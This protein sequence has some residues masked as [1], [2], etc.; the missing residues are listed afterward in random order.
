[1]TKQGFLAILRLDLNQSLRTKGFWIYSLLFGGFV[2]YMFISGI[3]ES[4]IIGFVGLGRLLVTFMQV[5]MVIIPIYVLITVVRSI[6]GDKENN[7]MEYMLSLPVSFSSF[8]WGKF[9]AKFIVI[10]IPLLVAFFG[11]VIWGMIISLDVPWN[12]FWLYS[13]LLAAMVFCFLG[14]GMFISVYTRSQEF[15]VSSAFVIWLILVAFLDLLL[16]GMMLKLRINPDAVIGVGM[17]NPLQ[18]FRVGVL[19]L[20]DPKLTTMGPAAYYILDTVSRGVFI[21]FAII[22]PTLLGYLFAWLGNKRFKNRDVI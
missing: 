9:F 14:I 22:Y 21:A 13:S 16:M 4:Q 20:F 2:A 5:C 19:V 15:A 12:L 1:M 10:Y 7:V 17:L 3:T 18:V 6:V 11:A 8:Y